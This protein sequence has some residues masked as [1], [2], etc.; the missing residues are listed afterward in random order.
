M[1]AFLNAHGRKIIGWDEILQGDLAKGATV[2]SWRGVQ[3][4]IEAASRG[5]DAVMTPNGYC[6]FDF[7]QTQERDKEPFGIG[8]DLSLEK[9]YSYEPF[10]GLAPEAEGHILGVQANLWTEYIT[11]PEHLEYML[12]PRMCALSEVQWCAADK[13]DYARF[14]ASLD[15]TFEMLDAMGV[16]YSLDCRGLVGLDRQP[17]RSAEE[18]EEYLSHKD[19]GW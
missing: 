3:G 2:M 1:Q 6:Y 17:A 8:G 12:L 9:V 10:E 19:W 18:M 11:T 15:H 16:N 13:K 4:G 7:Y 5:F 14:N